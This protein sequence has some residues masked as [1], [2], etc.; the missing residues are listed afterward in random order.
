L[1]RAAIQGKQLFQFASN[2]LSVLFM[3]LEDLQS[4]REQ[5]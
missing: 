4:G 5:I 1:G 3:A 2:L